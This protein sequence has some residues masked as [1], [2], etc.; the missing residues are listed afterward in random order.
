MTIYQ[1]GR[2]G[3]LGDIL[4]RKGLITQAQLDE[5]LKVRMASNKRLGEVLIEFGHVTNEQILDNVYTQLSERIHKV[6]S[7][8]IEFKERMGEFYLACA[9]NFSDDRNIWFQLEQDV[10]GHASSIRSLI[11]V[12]YEH[13]ELFAVNMSFTTES[14]E[15]VL[16]GV[17]EDIERVKNGDLGHDQALYIAR[18]IENSMLVSRLPDVLTTNDPVWK[19]YFLEQKQELFRHRKVIADAIAKVK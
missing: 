8:M 17:V 16:K 6:L 4:V 3:Q 13:P 1:Q 15:T 7:P 11:A 18:D 14:V 2:Q 19:K 5:A 9:E 12:L 10:S